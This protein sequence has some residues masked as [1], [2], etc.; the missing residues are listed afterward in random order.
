[1]ELKPITCRVCQNEVLRYLD[2]ICV[3]C[4]ESGRTAPSSQPSKAR[5]KRGGNAHG[6]GQREKLPL[7]SCDLQLDAEL[8]PLVGLELA[9]TNAHLID[10]VTKATFAGNATLKKELA[11]YVVR[12]LHAILCI[13][14]PCSISPPLCITEIVALEHQHPNVCPYNEA[15]DWGL[16]CDR[17]NYQANSTCEKN[18][19]GIKWTIDPGLQSAFESRSG[20]SKTLMAGRIRIKYEANRQGTKVKWHWDITLDHGCFEIQTCPTFISVLQQF[21]FSFIQ[22]HVM[23]CADLIGLSDRSGMGGCQ[24]NVDF[25]TGLQNDYMMILRV[26]VQTERW[27]T[28]M[29][30]QVSCFGQPLVLT[31]EISYNAAYLSDPDRP[32]GLLKE[33]GL[34]IHNLTIDETKYG[35]AW[36]RN[37]WF[38]EFFKVYRYLLRAYPTST[39]VENLTE[40]SSLELIRAGIAPDEVSAATP[41]DFAE[42][43]DIE[44][45]YNE[46][47]ER[48]QALNI[49]NILND[50]EHL[51]RVEF[52]DFRAVYDI[53]DLMRIL[54]HVYAILLAARDKNDQ[55][56]PDSLI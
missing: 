46:E 1:M 29:R 24:I 5:G 25:D 49:T 48:F 51:R 9:F 21:G 13:D 28:R 50:D 43:E 30:S 53:R 54:Q 31:G 37:E 16:I 27:R 8:D 32:E 36:E 3:A 18:L 20:A 34:L 26:I 47:V 56:G 42:L 44:P 52:R 11:G 55:G 17:D 14:V 12:W 7:E 35:G 45:P 38:K 33:L 4:I 39:Q 10:A 22:H 40:G 6:R 19:E 41:E 15:F 23:H 2:G